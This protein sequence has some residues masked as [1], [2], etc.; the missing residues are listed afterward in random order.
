M[1][2]F[3]R[4]REDF[5]C[6]NCG[7]VVKGDGYTDHCP[8]CLWGKHVDREIPGDR[9]SDCGGM[10]EPVATEYKGGKYK[11]KYKCSKCRHVFWVKEGK[12]DNRDKLM[13]LMV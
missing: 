6:E 1:K 3:K 7:E 13:E 9:E 4:V 8:K 11:I 10:M 2:N 12:G 5:G